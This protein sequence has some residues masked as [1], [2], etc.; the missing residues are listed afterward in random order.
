MRHHLYMAKLS[1]RIITIKKMCIAISD[2][3]NCWHYTIVHVKCLMNN[4]NNNN[5]S[6]KRNL[7]LIEFITVSFHHSSSLNRLIDYL[8]LLEAFYVG[9]VFVFF[10]IRILFIRKKARKK[11]TKSIENTV[12][13]WYEF[14]HW[15][16]YWWQPCKKDE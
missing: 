11:R 9:I 15:K 6:D 1:I 7:S 10:C 12:S 4:N 16:K 8:W 13:I 2:V 5:K 3:C 14:W